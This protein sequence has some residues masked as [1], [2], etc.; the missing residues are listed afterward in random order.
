MGSHGLVRTGRLCDARVVETSM[1]SGRHSDARAAR[2]RDA[3]CT[4]HEKGGTKPLDARPAV[5]AAGRASSIVAV[6]PTAHLVL[7]LPVHRCLEEA[8]HRVVETP[9]IE[10]NRARAQAAS[11]LPRENVRNR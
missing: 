7:A 6:S 8:V 10:K 5:P 2:V 4:M 1:H 3:R 11:L 9:C